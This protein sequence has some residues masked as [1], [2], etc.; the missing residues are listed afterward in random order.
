M[1]VREWKVEEG[2][3][4]VYTSTMLLCEEMYLE[5]GRD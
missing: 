5:R 4:A 2:K 3:R 1:I